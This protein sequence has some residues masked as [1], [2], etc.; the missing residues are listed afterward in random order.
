[1]S[2]LHQR[3]EDIAARLEEHDPETCPSQEETS[4]VIYA[5]LA[6][7]EALTGLLWDLTKAPNVPLWWCLDK[8]FKDKFRTLI[9]SALPGHQV[10]RGGD[11]RVDPTAVQ[12]AAG[13]A[14]GSP[15]RPGETP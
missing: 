10:R 13:A 5:L 15:Q 11:G 7:V 2:D 6:D 4:A 3:A 14:A 8:P 12:G 9:R 1:V